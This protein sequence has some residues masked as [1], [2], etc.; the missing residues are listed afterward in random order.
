MVAVSGYTGAVY[1]TYVGR[2]TGTDTAAVPSTAASARYDFVYALVTDPG[3][4]GQPTTG[5]PIKTQVVTGVASNATKMSDVPALAGQ[6]GI[7]LARIYRGA[8]SNIVAAG[9]ITDLRQN[10]A[11]SGGVGKIEMWS[12]NTTPDGYLLCDGRAVSR[13]TY[14]SL[15]AVIGLSYGSGDGSST[16]ALPDFRNKFPTMAG[17]VNQQG[18]S[19]S[20]TIGDH[21]HYVDG[22]THT[23]T[24]NPA[25]ITFQ[26]NDNTLTGDPQSPHP[27]VTGISNNGS[28]Q[29]GGSTDNGGGQNSRMGGGGSYNIVNPWLSIQFIIKAR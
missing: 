18:G 17:A 29:H 24:T 19:S 13:T 15:Y 22:H 14:S 5:A 7:P 27:R 8:N 11:S 28:H 10:V 16:F 23:F 20:L 25:N 2:N 1:E 26:T 21:Q 6:T 12:T 4:T 9:D 3:Q